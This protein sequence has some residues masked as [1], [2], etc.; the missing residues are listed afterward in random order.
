MAKELILRKGTAAQHST[1]IGKLAE[2]TVITDT[3]DLALHDNSTAGGI[4]LAKK[5][6]LDNYRYF[7]KDDSVKLRQGI[8]LFRN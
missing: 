7:T 8:S 1:F 2:L 5:I 6:N 3:K 4:V